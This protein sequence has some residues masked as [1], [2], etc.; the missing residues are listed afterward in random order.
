QLR[1]ALAAGERDRGKR[2]IDGRTVRDGDAQ[3]RRSVL[4]AVEARDAAADDRAD[5]RA[6]DGGDDDAPRIEGLPDPQGCGPACAT[7]AQHDAE[8]VAGEQA[9]YSVVVAVAIDAHVVVTV[10]GSVAHPVPH[11]ARPNDRRVVQ[12]QQLDATRVAAE[13]TQQLLLDLARTAVRSGG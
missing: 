6:A 11:A 4:R 10:D 9:R 13:V 3:L 5:A 2:Q 7:P 8:R 12:Q 1:D